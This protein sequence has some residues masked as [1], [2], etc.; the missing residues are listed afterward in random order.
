MTYFPFWLHR[1]NSTGNRDNLGCS[2]HIARQFAH[3]ARRAATIEF[4]R[5]R[6][7]GSR[8]KWVCDQRRV[9]NRGCFAVAGN[10][11]VYLTPRP[12][13]S[14]NANRIACRRGASSLP[15]SGFLEQER[16]SRRATRMICRRLM[17]MVNYSMVQ[18][19]TATV[20]R[21]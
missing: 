12:T 8:P 9:E 14:K 18:A 1:A 21:G 5:T 6:L 17:K 2:A 20:A 16:C 13:C 7:P 11:S 15:R 10:N 19:V 4:N 3:G